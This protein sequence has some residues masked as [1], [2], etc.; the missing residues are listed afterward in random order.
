MSREISIN[1][2][3]NIL[4]DMRIL[5]ICMS[6]CVSCAVAEFKIYQFEPSR[7]PRIDGDAA[8]WA[9]VPESYAVGTDRVREINLIAPC[10]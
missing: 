1:V 4:S 8:D 5:L 9:M 2:L 3:R 10:W 7:M 6:V